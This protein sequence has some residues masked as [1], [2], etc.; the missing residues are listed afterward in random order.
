MRSWESLPPSLQKDAVRPY[1]DRLKQKS[2]SLAAK[3]V[4]DAVTAFLMLLLLF[5]LMLVIALW[6]ALDSPGGVFFLQKRVTTCGRVFRIVK[7]RT[8][9]S[10][11][12][13]LGS[14]VTVSNDSRVTRA[15]KILRKLRLDE[16]PQLLNV[17]K[18][19]MSFVG[20]R[21]EVEKYVACYT[22]EMMATLLMPAGI[23]S[24]ASI[25]F[26]DEE[27]LL[28]GAEDPDKVYVETILPQKMAYNLEYLK[29]FGFF[30]DIALMFRTV[31]AVLR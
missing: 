12:E 29:N 31:A 14:S 4:F 27:R 5:P 7:F 10:R 11:A 8:M 6:V 26:K 30:S 3:R 15:G 24:L 19:D 22:D 20:T 17:L 25:R 16:L 18:G 9:V 28:S 13:T 23:T 1:Y 21:P 2:G